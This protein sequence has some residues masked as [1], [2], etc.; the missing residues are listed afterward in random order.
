MGVVT[1]AYI[2]K[3]TGEERIARGTL[4]RGISAKFDAWMDNR[5][6]TPQQIKKSGSSIPYWDLGEDAFR[7]F[8]PERLIDIKI[9]LGEPE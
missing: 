1:F 8:N 9:D 5:Q 2:K 6:D 3:K 4:R 7:S